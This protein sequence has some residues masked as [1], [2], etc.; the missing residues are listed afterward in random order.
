MKKL[1]EWYNNEFKMD[2]LYLNMQKVSENN[3]WHRERNVAVHTDMVFQHYLT[4]AD[5]H[6]RNNI[7]GGFAAIFHDV[8]KPTASRQNDVKQLPDGSTR[9]SF[10]GHEQISSRLWEDYV[11]CHWAHISSTF[12]L[13]PYDIYTVSWLI[14][15]HKPWGI[16]KRNKL[17]N[18][19]STIRRIATTG[20]YSKILQADTLGR[21]AVDDR[22]NIQQMQLWLGDLYDIITTCNI[23]PVTPSL[24]QP[25][26]VIPIGASGSGKSTY[27]DSVGSELIPYSWDDLRLELYNK[28]Y[29][30]AYKMSTEDDTFIDTAMNRFYEMIKMGKSLYLD[31]INISKKRRASFINHARSKGY[32]IK[33]V[34]FPC[35]LNELKI[36]QH[37]RGDKCVPEFAVE[38]HYKATQM[39]SYGEFDDITVVGSNLPNVP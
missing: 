4:L 22:T 16:K 1:I 33:A 5:N 21:I 24:N 18:I 23:T 31:N 25:I 37:N 11:V 34:L 35:T 39:P 6:H 27:R 13:C 10:N 3:S 8:G 7:L 15:Y 30:I 9:L 29:A 14:E 26:M 2:A 36:R 38:Q 32:Y 28:D 19:A 20:V 17:N 12:N